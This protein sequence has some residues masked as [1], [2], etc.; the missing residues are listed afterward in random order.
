MKKAL[1]PVLTFAKIDI[2]RLF[3]DKLA[4]FLLLCFRCCFFLCLVE[5]LPAI[6]QT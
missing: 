6:T 4:I 3:R 2:R 1:L 5:F